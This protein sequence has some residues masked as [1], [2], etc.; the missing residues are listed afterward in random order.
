MAIALLLL[1][2]V[3]LATLATAFAAD[4]RRTRV[5]AAE[6][7][8]RQVL[9]AGAITAAAQLDGGEVPA[10]EKP[11]TL[12]QALADA[13]ATA[14]ITYTRQGGQ[15]AIVHVRGDSAGRSMSQTLHFKRS[16]ATWA[17]ASAAID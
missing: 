6:A 12:P 13:G 2:A 16:G 14:M 17:I 4:A 8:L 9:T 15:V 3:T 1:I 11:L 7:Q 10:G 5:R